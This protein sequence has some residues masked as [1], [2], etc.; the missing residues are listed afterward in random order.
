[1]HEEDSWCSGSLPILMPHTANLDL[2]YSCYV[3]SRCRKTREDRL[4]W[5]AIIRG[6]FSELQTGRYAS[7]NSMKRPVGHSTLGLRE[8]PAI[9]P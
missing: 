8:I 2:R 9:Y 5:R 1:M 6:G 7:A 4:T 3:Y